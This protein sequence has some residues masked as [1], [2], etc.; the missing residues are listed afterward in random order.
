MFDVKNI[1]AAICKQIPNNITFKPTDIQLSDIIVATTKADE[2]AS[3]F[4]SLDQ[5][6]SPPI[7]SFYP[8]NPLEHNILA[9]DSTSAVLGYVPEG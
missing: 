4:V 6:T 8:Q 2:E 1:V 5:S 9:V 3:R 7:S